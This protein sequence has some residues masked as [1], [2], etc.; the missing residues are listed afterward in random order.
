MS[1]FR[2]VFKNKVVLITGHTGFKGS[3]LSMWLVS[4][5]AKVVGMSLDVP[6]NPSNY[7]SSHLKDLIED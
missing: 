2:D 1:K 7:E 4:L 6:S 5:G 3:W